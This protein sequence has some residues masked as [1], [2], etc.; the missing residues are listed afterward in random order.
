M[1]RGEKEVI[2]FKKPDKHGK[3]QTFHIYMIDDTLARDFKSL[4]KRKEEYQNTSFVKKILPK[5]LFDRVE[6]NSLLN[7]NQIEQ[8][9]CEKELQFKMHKYEYEPYSLAK[10]MDSLKII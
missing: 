8:Y 6:N 9:K 3:I 4:V 2:I 7:E 10:H 5:D 1:E